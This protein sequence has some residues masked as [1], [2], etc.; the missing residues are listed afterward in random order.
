[1]NPLIR[2]NTVSLRLLK[3][4]CPWGLL[5]D[6]SAQPDGEAHELQFCEK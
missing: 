1:M 2:A 5:F 4:D 6:V 3:S